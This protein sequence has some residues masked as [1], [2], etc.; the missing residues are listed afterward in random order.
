MG[1]GKKSSIYFTWVCAIFRILRDIPGANEN[2][3][4]RSTPLAKE[5]VGRTPVLGENTDR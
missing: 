4:A 3:N 5:W 2:K 1:L